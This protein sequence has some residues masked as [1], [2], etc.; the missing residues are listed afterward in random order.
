ML[1]LIF[2]KNQNNLL[3]K[4]L[5]KKDMVQEL[6]VALRKFHLCI[7]LVQEQLD[8]LPIVEAA[9]TRCSCEKVFRKY[10]ANLRENT[11]AEE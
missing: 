9:I 8:D 3:M 11:P 7:K 5:L 2:L 1:F 10:A 6:Y 4:E